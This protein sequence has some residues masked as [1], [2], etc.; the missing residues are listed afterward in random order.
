[1]TNKELF[2]KNMRTIELEQHSYCNRKCWFCPNTF[3]DRQGPVKWLDFDIYIQILNDLSC[4][5]YDQTI[6]FSGN[7]EP[8]SYAEEFLKR[9]DKANTWL[10]GAFLTVNTNTDYLTTETIE[11]SARAGLSVIKA[12]L[13]PVAKD[14]PYTMEN[15]S[16][17]MKRLSNKLPE[18]DFSQKGYG[19]WFALVDNMIIHAYSKDWAREVHN[20]CD[21]V[22]REV[23]PRMFTCGEPVTAFSIDYQG[24]ASPCCNIRGD[25]EP[26]KPYLLG[27]VDSTPGKIFKLYSGAILEENKY[28]CNVCAGKQWHPNGKLVYGEILKDL[29]NG[30]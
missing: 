10:P 25:Y 17:R 18:L 8:F 11:V 13:Y 29:K 16:L 19:Q 24:S 4:I 21:M 23:G 22:V 26:H 30:K 5:D 1:M 12:Q 7:C 28:P 9:V 15:I 3:I 20:K 6:S 14:E 27:K 2:K